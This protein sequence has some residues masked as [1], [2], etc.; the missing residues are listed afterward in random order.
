MRES[1]Q[2]DPIAATAMMIK[3]FQDGSRQ[4]VEARI[5]EAVRDHGEFRRLFDE[6]LSDPANSRLRPY[7]RELDYLIR[8]K[9][10]YPDEAADLLSS[11][12]D[13]RE[14]TAKKRTAAAK[15]VRTRATVESG[16]Q[17]NEPVDNDKEFYRLMKKAKTLD[18]MFKTLRKAKF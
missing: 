12:E 4:E 14:L 1:F 11:I 7:E 5:E 6:F 10:F 15:E 18:E 16:G 8:S 17:V 13:K 3:K 2:K 9:G